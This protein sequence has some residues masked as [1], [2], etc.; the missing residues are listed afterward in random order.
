MGMIIAVPSLATDYSTNF[1]DDENPISQ[2]GRWRVGG[3]TGFYKNPRT[4]SGRCFGA[5]TQPDYDDCLGQLLTP[6]IQGDYAVE[7][8]IYRD[9]TYTNVNTHEVGLYFDLTIGVGP[10]GI[11]AQGYEML[12]SLNSAF[13]GVKW[14]GISHDIDNF[15]QLADSSS[16]PTTD[17]Q[18]GDV[19]RVE[20]VGSLFTCFYNSV[21]FCEM[22]DSEFAGTGN[23]G[24]G[25]FTR[26]DA[27][28]DPAKFCITS[29]SAEA[30]D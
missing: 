30:L 14:L 10:G 1:P 22:D 4:L 11:Y 9:P 2:G 12:F 13:Q 26:P 28:N 18:T 24:M 29:W 15:E 7:V 8:V 25:F 27:G 17:F 23:P 21:E 3:V 19:F 16:P 20:R 6:S 5:I